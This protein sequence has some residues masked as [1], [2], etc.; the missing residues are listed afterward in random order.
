MRSHVY[1]STSEIGDFSALE[2]SGAESSI[3]KDSVLSGFP[4]SGDPKRDPNQ[5]L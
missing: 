2:K 4:V 3:S 1:D 5:G